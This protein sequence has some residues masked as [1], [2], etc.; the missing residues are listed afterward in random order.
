[1][2]SNYY[3]ITNYNS[4]KMANRVK[5]DYAKVATTLWA[6]H[7]FR[8]SSLTFYITFVIKQL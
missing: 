6:D 1:M 3:Y 4:E 7:W 5:V 8:S 2:T